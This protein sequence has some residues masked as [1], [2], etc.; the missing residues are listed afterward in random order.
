MKLKNHKGPWLELMQ[1]SW[2]NVSS[3]YLPHVF[4][5]SASAPGQAFRNTGLGIV[6]TL[7]GH[8]GIEHSLPP[9]PPIYV[10]IYIHILNSHPRGFLRL[11]L[12]RKAVV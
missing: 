11:D 2:G 9:I 3:M 6:G 5:S 4:I 10:Y 1:K 8:S 12:R 7:Q